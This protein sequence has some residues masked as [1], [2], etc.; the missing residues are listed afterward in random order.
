MGDYPSFLK[1]LEKKNNCHIKVKGGEVGKPNVSYNLNAILTSNN[2]D[3][4]LL[5]SSSKIF[6]PCSIVFDN[7]LLF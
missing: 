4:V 1:E 7:I 3:L 5:I 2:F 6:L